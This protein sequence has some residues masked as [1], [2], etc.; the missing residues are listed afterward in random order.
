MINPGIKHSEGINYLDFLNEEEYLDI[1]DSLPKENQHLDDSDPDKFIADMG[2][3]A[4]Y[5][6]L[7][8]LDLDEIDRRIV[9]FIGN[10]YCGIARKIDKRRSN[11]LF[12]I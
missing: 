7:E 1:V 5:R 9:Y 12:S 6:L 8:R 4:L 3:E 2:A 10:L 11:P